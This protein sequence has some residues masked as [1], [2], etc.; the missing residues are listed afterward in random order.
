MSD[1]DF[2]TTP[3]AKPPFDEAYLAYFNKM[4]KGRADRVAAVLERMTDRERALV[5]EAAVMANARMWP[6]DAGRV[7]PD[8]QV[9]ADTILA[10]L[11][12]SDLYPT[13]KALESGQAAYCELF[14]CFIPNRPGQDPDDHEHDF[15]LSCDW[16]WLCNQCDTRI[17]DGPCP[18]HAPM[19][20]PGLRLAECDANPKHVLFGHD[21]DDYG[22]PCFICLCSEQ[23]D[24][25][26]ELREQQRHAKHRRW[27][28]G[29]LAHLIATV[30]YLLRLSYGRST[31]YGKYCDGCV[32]IHWRWS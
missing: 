3:P 18:E 32:T 14:H 12:M 13:V 29:W 26:H 5:R 19:E 23:A 4:E 25:L 24:E 8:S 2:F 17:D 11:T 31:H 16:G 30:A 10:C 22:L 9:F 6:R 1:V 28:R 21:R 15:K 27:P 7:P 20:F